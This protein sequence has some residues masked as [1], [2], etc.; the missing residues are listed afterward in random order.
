MDVAEVSTDL[1]DTD[2]TCVRHD[3]LTERANPQILLK[4]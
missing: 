4:D 3:G 2:D 1:V